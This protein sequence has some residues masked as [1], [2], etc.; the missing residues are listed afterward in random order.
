MIE[1]ASTSVAWSTAKNFPCIRRAQEY[2]AKE[3]RETSFEVVNQRN[4]QE[5][6]SRLSDVHLLSAIIFLLSTSTLLVSIIIVLNNE[7]NI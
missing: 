1:I 2:I 6:I 3:I 5:N 7:L 4:I